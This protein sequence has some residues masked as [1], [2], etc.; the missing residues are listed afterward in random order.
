MKTLNQTEFA[1]HIGVSKGYV[2][3]L[4]QAGRIVMAENGKVDVQASELLIRETEDANRDDVRARHAAERDSDAPAQGAKK[5]NVKDVHH[6]TFSEGRAKEQH[7]K[8][9]QAE[10]EYQKTIGELVSKA[11]MQAAV[12]DVVTTFRQALE[13]MPHRISAELVGKDIDFVRS[14]LKQECHAVL[15][16]LS[17]EFHDKIQQQ[18]AS[19]A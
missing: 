10:L 13:N 7:Y 6:V 1:A 11:D 4:K 2:T 5:P 12:A 19:A 16:E 17:R 3:Q 18:E 8:S 9:L 14:S 15:A